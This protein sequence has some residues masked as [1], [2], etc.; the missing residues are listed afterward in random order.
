VTSTEPGD[1]GSISEA[2]ARSDLLVSATGAS[3]HIV[4]RR[5][6]ENAMAGRR[7]RSLVILDFA[8]PRDVDPDS[9]LVEGVHLID[10]ATLG[11]R[12]THDRIDTPHEIERARTVVGQEVRRWEIRRR[13]DKLG[14]LIRA[15]RGRGE[16]VVARE[17]ERQSSRLDELTRDQREAVEELANRIVAKLL[18]DPIV[19]LKERSEPGTERIHARVVSELFGIDP[20]ELE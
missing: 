11:E 8:V 19:G 7:G 15:L 20:A 3:G 17:L 6:I 16:E 9:A 1:L 5:Q 4:T 12:I 10:V 18:H 2:L 13:T 14:P